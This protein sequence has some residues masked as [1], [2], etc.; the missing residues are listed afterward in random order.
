M[1]KTYKLDNLDCANC[2]AKM[3]ADINGIGDVDS[4]SIAFMT[5]RLKIKVKDGADIDGVLD[6]AQK[7]VSKYEKDCIIIR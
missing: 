7:L 4:A 2:A 1:I 6:E 5:S 3:E